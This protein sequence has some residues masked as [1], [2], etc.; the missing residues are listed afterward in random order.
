MLNNVTLIGRL[1]RKPE[2]RYTGAGAAVANFSLAVARPYR[3]AEGEREVDF[4]DIATWRQL[5]ETCAEHLDKG[6]LVAVVGRLQIRAYETQ[7]GQRR[8]AAEVVAQ[9]VRFLDFPK[10]A[11][12]GGQG[13]DPFAS[14]MPG[15]AAP[16]GDE[17]DVPF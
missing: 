9:S 4:I 5:A 1:T 3:S 12:D 15:A 7:D 10:R 8:K 16:A 11:E 6:R 17:D 13:E 14:G 2:L